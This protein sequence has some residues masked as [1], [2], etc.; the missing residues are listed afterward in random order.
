M[1]GGC[2]ARCRPSHQEQFEVRYLA[3]GH[4]NMQTRGIEPSD[5]TLALPLSHSC[6]SS[7][8]ASKRHFANAVFATSATTVIPQENRNLKVVCLQFNGI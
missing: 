5:K 7:Q 4:F 2:H 6:L 1:G 8:A 3:Q